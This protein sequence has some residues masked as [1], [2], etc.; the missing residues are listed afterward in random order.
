MVHYD[1]AVVDMCHALRWHHLWWQWSHPCVRENWCRESRGFESELTSANGNQQ[2]SVS[3][4]TAAKTCNKKCKIIQ[5]C[6][7]KIQYNITLEHTKLHHIVTFQ[8]SYKTFKTKS[9]LGHNCTSFIRPTQCGTPVFKVSEL[10][11]SKMGVCLKHW[12][13]CGEVPLQWLTQSRSNRGHSSESDSCYSLHTK[14]IQLL[15]SKLLKYCK[16]QKQHLHDVSKK[17]HWCCTL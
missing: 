2:T 3:R 7:V 13:N 9:L 14:I 8:F 16:C 5:F 6:L 12:D 11:T 4:L 15:L 17:R 10:P 1:W